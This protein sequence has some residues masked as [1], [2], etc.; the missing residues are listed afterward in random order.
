MRPWLRKD[1]YNSD[2]NKY[3]VEIDKEDESVDE[4]L[5]RYVKTSTKVC[6]CVCVWW[7]LSS[8]L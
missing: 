1:K 3:H 7:F 2:I 6:P 8:L 4:D 5:E